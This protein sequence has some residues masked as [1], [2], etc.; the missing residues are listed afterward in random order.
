[1]IIKD[2]VALLGDTLPRT[3]SIET[4]IARDLRML[5]ANSTQLAQVLMNLGLNARDAMPQGRSPDLRRGERR[6]R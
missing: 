6:A 4:N 2:L 1:M 3:I 5:R